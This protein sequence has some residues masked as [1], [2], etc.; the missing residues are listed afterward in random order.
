MDWKWWVPFAV[1]I[2]NL[3]F[4]FKQ[5]QLMKSQ[6]ASD[7]YAKSTSWSV[8]YWP[9]IVMAILVIMP[10]VPYFIDRSF[11]DDGR[12]IKE[13][14]LA[15]K[16]KVSHDEI[17]S[18]LVVDAEGHQIDI[19]QLRENI[20]FVTVTSTLQVE[21]TEH[22]RKLNALSKEAR[23]QMMNDLKAEILR[24]NLE[25]DSD[26]GINWE[27]KLTRNFVFDKSVTRQKLFDEIYLV[28]QGM[29]LAMNVLDRYIQ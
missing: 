20:P 24:L 26:A 29:E 21:N 6:K 2:L 27:I 14:L 3:Y 18:F 28:N 23:R 1:S 9:I 5:I 16:M 17:F 8:K 19:Y 12:Q 15:S 22:R 13:W 7:P 25:V 4:G 11:S 10:W